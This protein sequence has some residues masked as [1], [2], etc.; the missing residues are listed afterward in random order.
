MHGMSATHVA[1]S[2]CYLPLIYY[3]RKSIF[4]KCPPPPHEKILKKAL[5]QWCTFSANNQYFLCISSTKTMDE[6]VR[7]WFTSQWSHH[8]MKMLVGKTRY[9]SYFTNL[10][11]DLVHSPG[12]SPLTATTRNLELHETC[13]PYIA[14]NHIWHATKTN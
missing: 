8:H 9:L 6:N 5:A 13:M 4:K 10:P 1:F 7:Q 14:R 2:H 12:E 3:H 11:R